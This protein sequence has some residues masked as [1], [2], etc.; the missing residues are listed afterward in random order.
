MSGAE[1]LRLFLALPVPSGIKAA[2]AAAQNELRNLLAPR[3]ASWTKAGN[4][5]LTLRFL[6]DV[7]SDQAEALIANVTTATTGFG[8]LPLVAERLGAFPDLR[9]P[10]VVW[11]WVHDG[12]DRLAELQRRVV[13][14]TD[15]LTQES[16]EEKFTGH[17]TL[18]R[19]KQIKRPQAEIIASFVKNAANRQ[20]GV[21]TAAHFELIRSELSPDG[22]R[23]TCL[24]KFSL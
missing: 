6:G 20:F 4:M 16:A 21:W 22:S 13:A 1:K 17:I 15:E 8:V 7:G 10:R 23:Y 12:A 2:L 14:A 19:V 11:A 5:H 18:A 9:Y 24:A 3:A